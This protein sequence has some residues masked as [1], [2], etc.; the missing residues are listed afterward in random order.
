MRRMSETKEAVARMIDEDAAAGRTCGM[1]NSWNREMRIAVIADWERAR[2]SE[3][4]KDVTIKALGDAL[5]KVWVEATRTADSL[6]SRRKAE[7]IC[8]MEMGVTISA[9]TTLPAVRDALL[10]A[11]RLP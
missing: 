11:G 4:E 7:D 2:A 8:G 1:S 5:E 9:E 3:V 10:L 6:P